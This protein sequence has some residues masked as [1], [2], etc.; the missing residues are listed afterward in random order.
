MFQSNQGI[1]LDDGLSDDKLDLILGVYKVFTGIGIQES[2]M[3][4]WPKHSIWA[5]SGLD[6][7]YWSESLERWFLL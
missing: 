1:F 5:K 3:S 2:H 6:M 4:W 7:G